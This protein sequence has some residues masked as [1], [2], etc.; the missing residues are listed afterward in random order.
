LNYCPKCH[1]LLVPKDEHLYCRVCDKDYKLVQND[2]GEYKNVR[3]LGAKKEVEPPV[4][5][6]ELKESIS[7]SD[8]ESHEDYFGTVEE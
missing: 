5:D 4:V 3:R 7:K 2:K 1:N 8:R 6:N